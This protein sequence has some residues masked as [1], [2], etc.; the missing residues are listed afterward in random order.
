M[1]VLCG[2]G[3][4]LAHSHDLQR[5]AEIVTHIDGTH[6][7][8]KV[9]H[10]PIFFP[11]TTRNL[12]IRIR[13]LGFHPAAWLPITNQA[14]AQ[15]LKA[16][17]HALDAGYEVLALHLGIT[18]FSAEDAKPLVDALDNVEIP[19]QRLCMASPPTT[20]MPDTKGMFK[21][22]P[23]CQGGWMPLAFDTHGKSAQDIIDREIYQT[24]GDL[25]LAWGKTPEIYPVLSPLRIDSNGT[26]LP[27]EF[28]PWIEGITHHGVDFFS[29]HHAANT[30]K[31]LWPMLKAIQ[32]QCR[33]T[34]L[35]LSVSVLSDQENPAA[36]PQP[37]YIV[38]KAGDTVWGIITRYGLTKENFW[39][40]NAHLWDDRG[41]PRDP[42]YLQEGWRFRVK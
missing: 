40:W 26:F 25:S 8:A 9:G 32:L 27:E 22:A 2:K 39:L 7:F 23:Y 35:D 42:D 36:L 17:I 5:A 34:A 38:A 11:E 28:I 31:A 16:I 13:S 6:I 33:D 24:L 12:V 41:L 14:P 37:V 18:P 20:L 4:W 19:R 3:I 21:L 1:A 30:E 29:I 10:G 15:A